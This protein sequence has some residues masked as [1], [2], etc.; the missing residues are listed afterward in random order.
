MITSAMRITA[1]SNSGGDDNEFYP[2]LTNTH[3]Y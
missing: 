1:T 2:L 3:T